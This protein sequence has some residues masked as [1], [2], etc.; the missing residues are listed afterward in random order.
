MNLMHHFHQKKEIQLENHYN[1][2]VYY[3]PDSKRDEA[4]KRIC[5][6][7]KIIQIEFNGNT[8]YLWVISD[9]ST[10]FEPKIY[11]IRYYMSMYGFFISWLCM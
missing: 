3:T 8:L 6:E 5:K 7:K 9:T 10:H 1:Q 11:I 2:L 4:A